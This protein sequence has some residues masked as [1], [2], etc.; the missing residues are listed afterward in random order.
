MAMS[1][2]II[3]ASALSGL[4]ILLLAGLVGIWVRNYLTFRT[5]LT[6]G[7]IAFGLILSAEN[8]LAIYFFFSTSMLYS[9]DPLAQRA[10]LTLRALQLLALGFLTYV[11]A[12]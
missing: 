8:A 4:S 11:T 7:L 12:Q 3:V 9:G 6:L 2:T 1:T 10:V 5:S